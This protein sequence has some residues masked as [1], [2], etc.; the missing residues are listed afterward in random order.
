[1]VGSQYTNA[2]DVAVTTIEPGILGVTDMRKVSTAPVTLWILNSVPVTGRESDGGSD[3]SNP[4]NTDP[5]SKNILVGGNDSTNISGV[6]PL[7]STLKTA[8][9]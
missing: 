1:V 6:P 7:I 9:P 2:S 4:Y 3:Q 5:P 8:P